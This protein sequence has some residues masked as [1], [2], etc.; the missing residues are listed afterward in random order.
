MPKSASRRLKKASQVFNKNNKK[1]AL[2]YGLQC[3]IISSLINKYGTEYADNE[4]AM[5]EK[6]TAINN[7]KVKLI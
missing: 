1:E 3:K 2:F 7:L 5:D 4:K 6:E